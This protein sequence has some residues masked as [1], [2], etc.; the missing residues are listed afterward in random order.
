MVR[1]SILVL[2]VAILWA[3]RAAAQCTVACSV[4]APTTGQTNVFVSFQSRAAKCNCGSPVTYAWTFGDGGTA[5]SANP[6]H[7]YTS[8][9]T[10]NWQLVVTADSTTCTK[11]GTI[12]IASSITPS[13][14]T[15]SGTTNAGRPFSVTVNGSSQITS[16]TIGHT[17]FGTGSTTSNTTCSIVNG[18]FTCGSAFCAPFVASS[19]ISGSFTSS[20]SVSGNATFRF[21]P[22]QFSSCCTQT[23]T[24]SATLGATALTADAA[25][26][27]GGG[28]A[29]LTVNFTGSATGG[30]SPYTY[31]WN[32]GDCSA[33]SS[34]QNP[35]HQYLAGNWTAFLTVTDSV[36]ATATD[37]IDISAAGPA[38]Q[39][40]TPNTGLPTGGTSVVIDGTNLGSASSVT[41]GGAAA[42][43]NG[44]TSTSITVTTPAHAAG[45]VDVVVTTPGG[46]ATSTGGFTYALPPF[47]APAGLA[48]TAVSTSQVDVTWNA[49]SDVD[50]YEVAR[51]TGGAFTTVATPAG[52]AYNDTNVAA[53]TSYVYK[54]RAISP[55]STASAYSAPDAATTIAFPNDPLVAGS[56]TAQAVHLTTLRTAVNAMR[57]AAGL[58][59]M[60]FTDPSAGAGTI[61]KKVHVEEARSALDGARSAIGLA[62][63]VYTDPTPISASTLMKAAHVQEVRN[64]CK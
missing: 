5:D 39:S 62:A 37:S 58:A 41:F 15:Y 11:S 19:A 7:T 34:T 55:S 2:L 40:I 6:S 56:T 23:P 26:D 35:S 22:N 8:D 47:G 46:T 12:T 44:N 13:A 17:C 31:S 43:I 52:T 64:G 38:I 14:G 28:P 57:V 54:V 1:R 48:A 9:G 50:H 59:P 29:P 21:T 25:V 42:S 32:F 3:A 16:W 20:T 24:F 53:N 18:N 61:V 49:V 63:L 51:S 10:Y 36:N 33:T 60:S 4:T 45:A 30:S 27:V